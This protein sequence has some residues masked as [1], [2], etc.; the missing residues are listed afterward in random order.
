M[1]SRDIRLLFSAVVTELSSAFL[2]LRV[3]ETRP[4]I[5]LPHFLSSEK[6]KTESHIVIFY[7]SVLKSKFN[8]FSLLL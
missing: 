5:E 8:V 4:V 1:L 7:I 3:I 6:I 2:L